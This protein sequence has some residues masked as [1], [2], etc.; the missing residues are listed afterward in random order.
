MRL[1]ASI[2]SHNQAGLLS[3][4]LGDLDKLTF[5]RPVFFIITENSADPTALTIARASKLFKNGFMQCVHNPQPQGFGAN[6]N[7]AFKLAAERAD[8]F[9]VLNPDLRVNEDIF[10]GL[11]ES[12]T[13]D[14]T[15]GIIAPEVVSPSGHLED[16]A[17][18]FPSIARI[19]RKLLFRDRGLFPKHPT[20]VY[21]PD[22]MAGMCMGF[23]KRAYKELKGFDERYFMYYEDADICRRAHALKYRPAVNPSH[24]VIHA[25]QRTSHRNFNLLLRHL[26]SMFR[27]LASKP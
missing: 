26:A 17:R 27:F 19:V 18:Y 13:S 9:F 1:V 22:W 16:N 14:A 7:Q 5:Q 2:I 15:I 20:Q 3:D 8:V 4:L 10:S 25:A 23:T 6:H 11:S 21:F 24:T 12:L